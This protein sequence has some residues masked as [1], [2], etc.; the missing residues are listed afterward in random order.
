MFRGQ[1]ETPAKS[2]SSLVV[3]EDTEVLIAINS[4]GIYVLDPVKRIMFCLEPDFA[5]LKN[6]KCF[7]HEKICI[8]KKL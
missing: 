8:K 6:N 4:S 7:L 1:I 5:L 2:L 3:N